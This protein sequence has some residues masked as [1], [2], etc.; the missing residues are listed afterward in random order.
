MCVCVCVCVCGEFDRLTKGLLQRLSQACLLSLP[1]STPPSPPPSLVSLVRFL[2]HSLAPTLAIAI[3]PTHSAER[4]LRRFSRARASGARVLSK[5]PAPAA[6]PSSY[7]RDPPPCSL[8]CPPDLP[9]GIIC[10]SVA[11]TMGPLC[12]C[13]RVWARARA[14]VCVRV[15]ACGTNHQSTPTMG[16][17]AIGNSLWALATLRSL[18]LSL[19]VCVCVCPCPCPCHRLSPSHF[20]VSTHPRT[21]QPIHPPI[22]AA[23]IHPSNRSPPTHLLPALHTHTHHTHTHCTHT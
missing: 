6:N 3:Y 19:S 23:S 21:H 8:S 13:L 22:C 2:C 15:R 20:R 1:P 5:L 12:A 18:S 14:R 7:S 11:L 17:Q 4:L 10:P 9:R 16:P